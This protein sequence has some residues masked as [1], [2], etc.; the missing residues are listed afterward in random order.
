M[1][2]ATLTDVANLANVSKM[3]VSRYYAAHH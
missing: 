1:K 3:T 2:T